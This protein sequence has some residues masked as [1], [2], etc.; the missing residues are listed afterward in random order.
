MGLL[1]G[2]L[3]TFIFNIIDFF[4]QQTKVMSPQ[5]GFPLIREIEQQSQVE[6]DWSWAELAQFWYRFGSHIS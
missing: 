6:I 3:P 1:G 5:P 4:H 2:S